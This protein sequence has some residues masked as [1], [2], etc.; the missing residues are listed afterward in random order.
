MYVVPQGR[1]LAEREDHTRELLEQGFH[2]IKFAEKVR[3]A[4]LCL[5]PLP[6]VHG[7]VNLHFGLLLRFR[8]T[9]VASASTG[10]RIGCSVAAVFVLLPMDFVQQ[11]PILLPALV[12]YAGFIAEAAVPLWGYVRV[13]RHRLLQKNEADLNLSYINRFYWPLIFVSLVQSGSGPL[14]NLFVARGPAPLPALA[15][16]VIAEAW[17]RFCVPGVSSCA[18]CPPPLRMNRERA[19][20]SSASASTADCLRLAPWCCFSG[21]RCA[22]SSC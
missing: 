18:A 15:A 17:P 8:Q 12:T 11:R 3:F 6:L 21:R 16:L 19:A 14:V 22:M 10:A 9:A 13:V 4:L 7:F 2:H 20:T 5:V 1:D